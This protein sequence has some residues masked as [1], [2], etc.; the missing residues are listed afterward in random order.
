MPYMP[1]PS[2]FAGYNP[3]QN[4]YGLP[5]TSS[6]WP[7]PGRDNAAILN[8]TAN[9][10]RTTGG[11]SPITFASGYPTTPARFSGGSTIRTISNRAPPRP[12][13][14]PGT[15]PYAE[16]ASLVNKFMAGQAQDPFIANLPNY[17]DL[18]GQRSKNIGEQLS[19]EVSSSTTN[20]LAQRG[21]ERGI[22]V[23]AGGP[24]A[25]AA[26]LAALG[27]TAEGVKQKGMEN[28]STAIADTPVPEIWNPM[29]LYVPEYLANLELE[30][31]RGP[32]YEGIGRFRRLVP[33]TPL[34]TTGTSSAG[35][36]NRYGRMFA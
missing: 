15:V 26:W 7:P 32:Q 10:S 14:P 23:G 13:F 31:T 21:A 35:T 22:S 27:L 2:L 6:V 25:A 9:S 24:N 30:A 36:K 20:L 28:L 8:A 11:Y 19:G 5:A 33:Q 29:S 17:L 3:N 4:P 34:G 18:I 12:P 1:P 16:L